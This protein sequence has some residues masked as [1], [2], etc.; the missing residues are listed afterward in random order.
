MHQ[1]YCLNDVQLVWCN[2]FLKEIS[3]MNFELLSLVKF[4]TVYLLFH[5]Y[6]HSNFRSCIISIVFKGRGKFFSKFNERFTVICFS[7]SYFYYIFYIYLNL[8]SWKC[9]Y[10][11]PMPWLGLY[12]DGVVNKDSLKR[13]K[14]KLHPL[15]YTV[16]CF[17]LTLLSVSL[18]LNQSWQVDF[19]LFVRFWI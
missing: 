6:A 3:P 10:W 1:P 14:D 8:N 19:I 7:Q 12:M 9:T 17:F 2:P 18:Y 16:W 15:H 11:H 13:Q 4:K 5:L